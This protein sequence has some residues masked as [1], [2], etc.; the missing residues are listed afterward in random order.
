MHDTG[1]IFK[2]SAIDEPG[3]PPL[4][5]FSHLRW[6][7]VTQR[8]QHLMKR[9]AQDQLVFVWEEHI[10]CDHPLPFLEHHPFAADNVIA[11]RP[12][13]PHWWTAAQVEAG[14]RQ[15]LD[16][17]IATSI[18]AKPVLWFY[19]PMMLPFAEHL[20][21]AAVVY[22]CMDE[23]SAFRFA[24]PALLACESRLLARA[25][26]VFTGGLSLHEAKRGRHRD[27]HVFPS[28]VDV[29]HFAKSRSGNIEP[30]D[31]RRIPGPKLGFFGVIDER[32]DLG[33]IDAVAARRPDWSFVMIG[34]VVKIDPASLPRRPNL[35][36]LGGRSYQE[37]PA[38]LSG[39]DVA[40]MP[41][42]IN[43]ATRF[44]SPTKT[45]EYL[46]GGLPVV[47]TPIVDVIHDYGQTKAVAIAADAR[48]FV[49][50]CDAALALP[51][52]GAWLDETDRLLATQ[53]WDR[54]QADMAN[55]IN[56]VLR[57]KQTYSRMVAKA[58][59]LEAPVMAAE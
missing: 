13:L 19:T 41:F 25:D 54:T 17:L 51:R 48:A 33:L 58:V 40:L 49:A 20:D 11:L 53:S 24:D 6:D 12:R 50:A 46:A 18:R 1:S 56:R 55:E 4:I 43:A 15:L 9:F 27:V 26:L 10:A 36:W 7:F 47:S 57:G 31:Q 16:S 35:H 23:L 30:D 44:I 42:A 32:I 38:Y 22:D 39:W 45:P 8:P 14:L 2:H 21:A 29:A 59:A 5:C 52:G 3:P 37:L 34:P 28:A